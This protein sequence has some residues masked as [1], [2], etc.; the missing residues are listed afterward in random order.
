MSIK[1]LISVLFTFLFFYGCTVPSNKNEPGENVK[2]PGKFENYTLLPNGWKLTPAGDQIGIGELPLN[3]I[4]T[5]DEKYA[6]TSNSGTKTNSISVI[7]LQSKKEIQ[8]L[9]VDKTW[10]GIVFNEDDSKLFVSGANNNLIYIYDFNSGHLTLNDSIII[11]KPFPKEEISITGLDYLRNNNLLFAVSKMSNSL[12]I[13]NVKSKKVIKKIKFDSEC[14]DVKINHAETF[15]YVSLWAKSTIAEVDLKTLS[16]TRTI[17]VGDHPTEI[18][19]TKNDERLFSPNANNNS[20][21]VVDLKTKK[22]T[23]KIISS[24]NADAPYGSTPNAVCFNKD[25]SVLIVANADNNYLALFDI[26]QKNKSKSIGFIPVGWYPTSVKTLS[27]NEIIVTNAKGL[28]SKPNP[29]GPVPTDTIRRPDQQYIGSLFMGT[30]S[31]INFP[32]ANTLQSYSKKV[33]SNTPYVQEKISAEGQNIIPA[34]YDNIG[35]KKIKHVFYI[36]KENRTY[37]QV[38]G[39]IVEG[40][41]DSSICIF[42]NQVS[43]NEHQLV[44][45]YTLYDNF[46]C[47]AEVSADGHNWSTAA[48]ATD[49]TEKTWPV[50]YGGRGGEYEYEGGVKVAAPSSGYIWNQVMDKNLSFRNYGEFVSEVKGKKITYKANDED[51]VKYTNSDYPGFDL[52]ISDMVRLNVWEKEFDVFVRKDSLP[53]FN[54]IRLP[55]DHTMGTRKGKLTPKAYVAQNDYALGLMIEKISKSKFWKESIIFVLEDDAQNGSDH[56]DA[57]RSTLLVVSPYIKRHFVD[58]TMYSTSSVLKTIELV[59]GLKP[60]TQFDLSATPILNSITDNPDFTAYNSLKP[61]IDVEAKNLASTYG[62]KRSGEFNFA[63]EDDI[64]DVE[65]NEIIWK[66]IKGKDSKMP[67]PVRSAFVTVVQKDKSDKD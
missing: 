35:S 27:S 7:D 48:Y 38:F 37:D 53:A 67:P 60:M 18:L 26:S 8:R 64:P 11:G 24:L 41:G 3:L 30:L 63:K 57:H 9:V 21:S 32:D 54:L 25:E 31:T 17:E 58:H 39:D 6:L 15:A 23:E 19:I 45:T 47:D 13:C 22:E 14:Y 12:Y 33:Y 66:S 51:M 5:L 52:G 20:V 4:I 61:L 56:V 2:L 62:S 55:N 1:K 29:K 46:Y 65:L 42:G 10:R 36:I 34:D 16:V 49:F 59:L 28:S 43:P 44:Q 40:N 50:Y